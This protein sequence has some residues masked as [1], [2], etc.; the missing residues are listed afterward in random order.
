MC[1][2]GASALAQ[3]GVTA[4]E[5]AEQVVKEISTALGSGACV[6]TWLEDQVSGVCCIS[7]SDHR[8]QAFMVS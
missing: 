8:L 2:A 6:D 4:E 5:V 3:K 7:C 1:A